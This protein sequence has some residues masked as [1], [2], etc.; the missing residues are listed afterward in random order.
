MKGDFIVC[1]EVRGK[2]IR[3]ERR[4]EDGGRGVGVGDD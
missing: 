4:G 2:D 1:G 3:M